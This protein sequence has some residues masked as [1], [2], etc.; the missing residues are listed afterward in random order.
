MDNIITDFFIQGLD[1]FITALIITF[2]V[3]LMSQQQTMAGIVSENYNNALMMQEYR[4]YNAYNHK[5]VYSSDIVSLIMKT[6]GFPE[7]KVTTTGGT[8]TF[9]T[10]SHSLDYKASVL[11]EKIDP[12]RLYDADVSYEDNTYQLGVKSVVFRP[13]SRN[14]S[15]GR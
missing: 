9:N 13:C 2:L 8:Y 5:H 11:S 12:N 10:S 15:C 14:G 3:V 1:S 4:E 6:K 7:V